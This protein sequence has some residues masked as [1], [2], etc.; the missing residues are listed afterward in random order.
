MDW[1]LVFNPVEGVEWDTVEYHKTEWHYHHYKD[2]DW[3]MS[4][5]VDFYVEDEGYTAFCVNDSD[6]DDIAWPWT[7]LESFDATPP[8]ENRDPEQLGCIAIPG[9]ELHDDAEH[10]HGFFD[11]DIPVETPD[12]DT[13]EDV[14]STV[15]DDYDGVAMYAHPARYTRPI[16]FEKYL[17]ELT[18][19]DREQL[20]GFEAYVR[21]PDGDVDW[22]LVD[23]LNTELAP[24]RMVLGYGTDDTNNYTTGETMLRHWTTMLLDPAEF[25]ASD[26]DGSRQAVREA[27]TAGR[28]LTHSRDRWDENGDDRPTVPTVN[29][30]DVEEEA[31]TITVDAEDYDRILWVSSRGKVVKEGSTL[32]WDE[33]SVRWFARARIRGESGETSTQPF[34][35]A[36][37]EPIKRAADGGI[38]AADGVETGADID[39]AVRVRTTDGRYRIAGDLDAT[40]DERELERTG[41][42]TATYITEE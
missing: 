39:D 15:V 40:A 19:W 33:D 2:D 3:S 16:E 18:T 6:G 30:I 4:D 34:G 38:V 10:V 8:N 14:I 24:D 29:S 26:Q 36:P 25:D 9:R 1:N 5:G 27:M 35:F 7:D 31:R 20:P 21:G 42:Q 11:P 12:Y 41:D 17:E 32:D 28:C 37:E 23:W 13:R 22:R